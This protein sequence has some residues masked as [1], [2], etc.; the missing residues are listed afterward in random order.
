MTE[1]KLY[2]CCVGISDRSI[3]YALGN[4][5]GLCEKGKCISGYAGDDGL[6]TVVRDAKEDS[7]DDLGFVSI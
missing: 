2:Y 6:C 1:E 3:D 5:C 7:L 4:G